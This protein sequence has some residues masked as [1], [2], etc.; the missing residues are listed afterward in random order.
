MNQVFA[1]RRWQKFDLLQG[2]L[3]FTSF[4][5]VS[6]ILVNKTVYHSFRLFASTSERNIRVIRH[7]LRLESAIRFYLISFFLSFLFSNFIQ[8]IVDSL[9]I[10]IQFIKDSSP[11]LSRLRTPCSYRHHGHRLLA[12]RDRWLGAVLA[13]LPFRVN[14]SSSLSS[15]LIN[16][17]S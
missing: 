17:L 15:F 12:L 9:R 16:F 2:I 5:R 3:T 8:F 14:F 1:R 7:Q 13:A 11:I 10:F 6:R 4:G